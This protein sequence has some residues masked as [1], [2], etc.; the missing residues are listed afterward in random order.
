M[1]LTPAINWSPMSATPAILFLPVRVADPYHLNA[2][3]DPPFHFNA[4]PDPAPHIG[5]L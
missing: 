1:S 2:D 3:P 4:D 5:D